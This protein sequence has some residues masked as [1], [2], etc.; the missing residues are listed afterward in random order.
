MIKKVLI[1]FLTIL[2]FGLSIYMYITDVKIDNTQYGKKE[3]ILF[4]I[5][6]TMVLLNSNHYLLSRMKVQGF[7]RFE[8]G[9]NTIFFTVSIMLFLLHVGLVLLSIGKEINLLLF[10]PIIVGFVLIV[11]ANTLPR[12][13]I[14]SGTSTSRFTTISEETWN[15]LIRPISYPLFIGGILILLCV[16]LPG[17]KMFV[18]F[19]TILLLTILI[20]IF[21]SY[22]VFQSIQ[23]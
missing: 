19:F 2:A 22:K 18:G 9:I 17:Y 10:V 20:S 8:K 5:P 21:R 14:E 15:R 16:F 13:K 12:F 6:F 3:V 23:K 1:S 11:T 4:V 7:S